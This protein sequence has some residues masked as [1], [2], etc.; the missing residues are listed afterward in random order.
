MR[1]SSAVFQSFPD[2]QDSYRAVISAMHRISR[3][4]H[5][6]GQ[7]SPGAL[8]FPNK[9][10]VKEVPAPPGCLRRRCRVA[11]GFTRKLRRRIQ[12]GG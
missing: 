1:V 8:G 11:L 10:V 5:S 12:G 7:V 2:F 3:L 6:P 4:A 9:L